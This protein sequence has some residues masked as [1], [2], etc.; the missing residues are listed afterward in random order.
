MTYIHIHI[1]IY[2][3]IYSFLHNIKYIYTQTIQN[4]CFWTGCQFTPTGVPIL[5]VSS[6]RRTETDDSRPAALL[7]RRGGRAEQWFPTT[8]WKQAD[9]TG[10]LSMSRLEVVH[11]VID[12]RLFCFVSLFFWGTCL[13]PPLS[14]GLGQDPA[15]PTAL[16][17]SSGRKSVGRGEIGRHLSWTRQ[18]GCST[19]GEQT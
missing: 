6:T 2:I 12:L 10:I 4:I 18:K 1:Y 5:S 8:P 13:H 11:P 14:Q 9:T 3:F 15:K 19:H 17:N 7:R 16:L